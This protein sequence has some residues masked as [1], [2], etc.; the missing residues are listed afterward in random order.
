MA[1]TSTYD[2]V[3]RVPGTFHFLPSQVLLEQGVH[4]RSERK[5]TLIRALFFFFSLFLSLCA[6][7]H[8][9]V[10][11]RSSCR[12]ES[13]SSGVHCGLSSLVPEHL[14]QTGFGRQLAVCQ[15]VRLSLEVT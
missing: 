3:F 13:A 12:G 4:G 15:E 7:I 1:D 9:S 2:D 11:R 5:A 10:F 14:L 8:G 6:C